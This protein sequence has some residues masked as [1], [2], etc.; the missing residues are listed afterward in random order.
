MLIRAAHPR[1][2]DISPQI[3]DIKSMQ[4]QIDYRQLNINVFEDTDERCRTNARLRESIAQSRQAQKFTGEHE[5]V[6]VENRNIYATQAKVTV[7]QKRTFEAAQAYAGT[8]VAVLNFA[9]ASS[10]GGGV[11][12]GAGAQEESLCRCSTLY[13]CLTDK[14]MLELF[15][16]PHRRNRTALHTDDCIYTPGVTVFKTD[17]STPELLSE[18]DWY[19]VD[20]I[21]CAAPNLR[22]GDVTITDEALK[23][24]HIKRLR[25]I[26]DIAV[27]NKVENIVLG[28]FGCGAFMNDPKVVASATA[29]VIRDYLFAFKAIEFAVFCRPGFEQNYREFRN[30]LGSE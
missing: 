30:Y 25:R 17:V 22:Y 24:L 26:L 23:Q 11:T 16:I 2:L 21:T 19:S 13:H 10:P 27:T 5:N 29:E 20:V 12:T 6:A 3:S 28:A 15:Y 4:N 14:K 8:R 7:S 1:P 18:K 9:S